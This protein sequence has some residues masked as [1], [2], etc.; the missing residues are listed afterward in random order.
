MEVFDDAALSTVA[1]LVEM[2]KRIWVRLRTTGLDDKLVNIVIDSCW[3]TKT[4]DQKAKPSYQLIKDGCSEDNTLVIKD[5]GMGLSSSFSFAA[6]QFSSSE[7]SDVYLHC[8]DCKKN[9]R[10]RRSVRYLRDDGPPALI[11]MAWTS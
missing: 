3:A 5:N 8:Q 1:T 6:F 4:D 9:G 7:K 2:N 10:R 11:T